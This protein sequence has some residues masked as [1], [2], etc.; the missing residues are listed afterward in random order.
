MVDTS[1]VRNDSI[2]APVMSEDFRMFTW[3]NNDKRILVYPVDYD[4]QFNITCTH[5]EELSDNKDK[6]E[7]DDEAATI[8]KNFIGRQTHVLRS[9]MPNK[10]L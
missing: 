2:M 7:G 9:R 8:G 10:S 4:R 5:P 3:G 1:V 6:P